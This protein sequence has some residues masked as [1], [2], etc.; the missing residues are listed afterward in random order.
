MFSIVFLI[1]RLWDYSIW[2][3]QYLGYPF[4]FLVSPA[5]ND[6]CI[7]KMAPKQQE[8]IFPFRRKRDDSLTPPIWPWR[9]NCHE[10]RDFFIEPI[11]KF[12]KSI[13]RAL[14]QYWFHFFLNFQPYFFLGQWSNFD[15]IIFFKW[16]GSTTS[17]IGEAILTCE[18]DAAYRN[19][20]RLHL[21]PYA[22]SEVSRIYIN[23]GCNPFEKIYS[24]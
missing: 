15:D 12:H 18:S 16:V 2:S 19:L 4:Y 21:T 7:L 5:T 13:P 14:L 22:I 23:G 20:S 11:Y 24:I 1:S 10:L 3:N 9:P 8:F 6:S 17:W